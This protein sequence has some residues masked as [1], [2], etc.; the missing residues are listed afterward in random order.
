MI[1]LHKC[2]KMTFLWR[3]ASQGYMNKCVKFPKRHSSSVS[4]VKETVQTF[5]NKRK[6]CIFPPKYLF[7]LYV[8]IV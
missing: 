5:N 8:L 6:R 7:D 3:A 1:V 4:A 2:H